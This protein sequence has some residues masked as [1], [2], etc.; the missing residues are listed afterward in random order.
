MCYP[1][2]SIQYLHNSSYHAEAAANPLIILFYNSFK[3]FPEFVNEKN[4]S[5]STLEQL[6]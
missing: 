6:E 4:V 3:M 2:N 1:D 5:K